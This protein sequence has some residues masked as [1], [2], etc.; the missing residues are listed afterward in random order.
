MQGFEEI[1]SRKITAANNVDLVRRFASTIDSMNDK[2]VKRSLHNDSSAVKINEEG[3]V[4]RILDRIQFGKSAYSDIHIH[5]RPR[6]NIERVITDISRLRKILSI[7]VD[8]NVTEIGESSFTI[9]K[10]D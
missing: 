9:L 6:L 7:N 1:I 8:F 2:C 5:K 3:F 10:R 4:R